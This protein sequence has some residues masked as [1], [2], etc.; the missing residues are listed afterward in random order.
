MSKQHEHEQRPNILLLCADMAAASHFGCYGDQAEVTPN[1]D[2]LAASGTRFDR[3]YCACPPCIP[4]RVSM[5]TGLYGHTHGKYAH[6]KMPLEPKPPVLPELLRDAGYRTALVGKTH[7]WPSAS[8]LG[9]DEAHITIDNHLTPELGRNDAYIRFLESK[10]L[11][12]YN[13]DTWDEDKKG[14]QPD[15][16]PFECLKPNWTGDMACEV[17]ERFSTASE[18]FFLFCSFVEPHGPGKAPSWYEKELEGRSLAPVIEEEGEHAGKPPTQQ[19]AAQKWQADRT[20][21]ERTRLGVYAGI[22]LVDRNIGK[23]L[24]KL[25]ELGAGEN[26]VVLF[27]TDHGDLMFDHGLIEKT[28]LYETAVRVPFIM[29]GPGVPAGADRQHL[30]S[31][32]DLLPTVMDMCGLAD[33]APANVEGRSVRHVLA[34][35]AAAW[36]ES[37]FCESEQTVHVRELVDSSSAKMVIQGDWKYIYTL[38]DGHA[39]EE[40]LYDLA[41]DPRELRNRVHDS[42]QQERRQTMRGE[43]LRWMVATEPSRL[44]P[45]PENHYKVPRV[46]RRYL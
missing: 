19:R 1:V 38:V 22:S 31:H 2:A 3:A 32:V 34:D 46:D 24:S 29:R 20:K 27:V 26:T 35:P 17:L 44:H 14:L 10:G 42:D 18:P 5:F 13:P 7:W 25:D 43:I 21:K 36:R 40:E 9:C 30:V 8:T 16:L 4:T 12:R 41:S 37:L 15:A 11:F 45:A 33:R 28:F 39:V 6:L 23:V